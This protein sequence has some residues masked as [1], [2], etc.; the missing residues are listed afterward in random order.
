MSKV[1]DFRK[2]L[3][4]TIIKY[5]ERFPYQIQINLSFTFIDLIKNRIIRRNSVRL[6]IHF[7]NCF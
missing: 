2:V 4:F 6:I 7:S 5:F 1:N 3:T